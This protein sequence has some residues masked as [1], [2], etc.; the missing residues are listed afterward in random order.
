[1]F[2]PDDI[3]TA[4]I[5]IFNGIM[6]RHQFDKWF[7]W[8]FAICITYLW[9]F[10]LVL[11]SLHRGGFDWGMAFTGALISAPVF[12]FLTWLKSPLSK[13]VQIAIPTEIKQKADTQPDEVTFV[14][15]EGK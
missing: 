3:V 12:S 13:D 6:Q 10:S 8:V 4:G 14:K 7:K 1:M 11:G 2:G 9:S 5:G 15:G